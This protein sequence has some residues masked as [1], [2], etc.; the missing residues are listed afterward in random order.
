MAENSTKWKESH[1]SGKVFTTI[2]EGQR[3]N[4]LVDIALPNQ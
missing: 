2:N 1:N 4:I 3:V